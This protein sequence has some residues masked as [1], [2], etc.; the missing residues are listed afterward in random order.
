MK[1]GRAWVLTK[2]QNSD[3]I[4]P[5]SHKILGEFEFFQAAERR[6]ICRKKKMSPIGGAA[7][8]NIR[9]L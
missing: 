9:H 8:R 5:I 3:L 1:I 4:A 7:H 6:N 2:D